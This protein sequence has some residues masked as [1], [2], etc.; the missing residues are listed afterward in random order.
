MPETERD[1]QIQCILHIRSRE[2]EREFRDD[3]PRKRYIRKKKT[4]YT[5]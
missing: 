3:L 4:F 2:I 5:I 1:Y